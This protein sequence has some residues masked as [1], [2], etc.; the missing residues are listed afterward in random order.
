VS[1]E[2]QPV[3]AAATDH[4]SGLAVEVGPGGV[5]RGLTITDRAMRGGGEHLARTLLR[6]SATAT[7]T[8]NRRTALALA[9]ELGGLSEQDR[10]ALGL[11]VDPAENSSVEHTVPDTWEVL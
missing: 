6:L 11:R 9:D 7:A 1:T 2:P 4:A 10:G 8:A 5:L 3:T